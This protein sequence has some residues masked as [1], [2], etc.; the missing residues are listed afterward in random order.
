MVSYELLISD[1]WERYLMKQILLLLCRTGNTKEIGELLYLKNKEEIS[2][3]M[4]IRRCSLLYTLLLEKWWNRT[5]VSWSSLPQTASIHRV[6]GTTQHQSRITAS[7]NARETTYSLIKKH[8]Q[9][10]YKYFVFPRKTKFWNQ[11]FRSYFGN[12]RFCFVLVLK[13]LSAENSTVS[14]EP[15]SEIYG[16]FIFES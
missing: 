15:W 1:L 16:L 7:M 10:M 14:L 2:P 8:I 11:R 12:S 6:S 13:P 3:R 9:F 5:A 4:I